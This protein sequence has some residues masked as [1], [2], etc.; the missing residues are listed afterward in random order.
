M[1]RI[2]TVPELYAHALAIEAEAAERYAELAERMSD[3]GREEL[4]GVFALLAQDEAEHLDALKRRTEERRREAE[5]TALLAGAAIDVLP[6]LLRSPL[7]RNVGIPVAL[8]VGFLMFAGPKKRSRP[9]DAPGG[10]SSF[11]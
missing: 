4:A 8:Y 10:P 11:T 5:T 6:D 9:V 3:E 7:V 2:Q 1:R